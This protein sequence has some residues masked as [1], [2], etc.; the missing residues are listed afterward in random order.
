MDLVVKKAVEDR[1]VEK[2][3]LHFLMCRGPKCVDQNIGDEVW[4]YLKSKLK[5]LGLEKKVYRSKV[6]CL[7]I[8]AQGPIG[9]L[10]PD[11]IWY[12]SVDKNFCDKL[13]QK[14]FIDGGT[15]EENVI[16]QNKK[17]FS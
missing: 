9:L 15:L 7:R 1:H 8:C 10:Y 12:H 14:V 11:G 17:I 16:T 13:I 4:S 3:E 6:D 2:Y 5:E